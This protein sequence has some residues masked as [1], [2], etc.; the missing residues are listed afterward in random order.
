MKDELL[1]VYSD[2]LICSFGQ[3]TAT[4]LEAVM[5]GAVSHDQISR[6]LNS[7]KRT[8]ADYWR[9]VKPVIRNMQS[10]AER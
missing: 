7:K 4:G 10:A 6:A 1:D 3:A 5:E 2:Y 8:G 9:I